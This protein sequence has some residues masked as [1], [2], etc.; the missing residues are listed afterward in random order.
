VAVSCTF[1][2]DAVD[3]ELNEPRDVPVV[4]HVVYHDWSARVL[5]D[6]EAAGEWPVTWTDGI[7]VWFERYDYPWHALARLAALVA[8]VE[9]EVFLVH[10]VTNRGEQATFVDEAERFVSRTVH[11]H[12][13]RPGCDGTG[14]PHQV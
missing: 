1:P 3:P 10:D 11:A 5:H 13:C 6:V 7:N 12:S 14:G 4:A 9:Q 8:A 2:L